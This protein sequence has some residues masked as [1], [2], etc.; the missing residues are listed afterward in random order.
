M[1]NVLDTR[2]MSQN[3]L[4]DVNNTLCKSIFEQ[5]DFKLQYKDCSFRVF[6][7]FKYFNPFWDKELT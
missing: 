2:E 6:R 1:I 5:M 7:K 4:N 3:S